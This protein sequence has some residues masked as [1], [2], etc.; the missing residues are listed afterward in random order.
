LATNQ[1]KRQQKLER[2]AAKRK[3]RHKTLAKQKNRGLAEQLSAAS[4][5]PVL[6]SLAS[7]SLWDEGMSQVLLSR[8]LPNGWIAVGMFLVDR[9]CLGV[10]DAFGRVLTRAEYDN[11]Y[12]ELD[13]KIDLIELEPADARS[14]VEGA[15]EYALGLGLEPHP[16]YYRVKPIFGDIDPR[17]ASERFEYGDEGKPHFIAGPNDTPQRCQRIMSILEHSCGS[18]GYHFT[19]PMDGFPSQMPGDIEFAD[20]EDEE[21]LDEDEGLPRLG[22]R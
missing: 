4:S 9:Y 18:G 17:D 11:L 15:V 19:I 7:D 5:A 8:E 3:R 16:D 12:E 14:L 21:F 20:E 1:K 10:K 22:W 2:R 13:E 6:H